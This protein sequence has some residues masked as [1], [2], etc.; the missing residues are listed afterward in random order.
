MA[1]GVALLG[2]C[3]KPSADREKGEDVKLAMNRVDEK[4]YECKQLYYQQA[5][6]NRRK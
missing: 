4:M 3:D 1:F 6:N 5:G 2:A